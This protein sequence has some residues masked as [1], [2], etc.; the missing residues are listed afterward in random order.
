MLLALCVL[1]LCVFAPLRETISFFFL[2]R[3]LQVVKNVKSIAAA[4]M[5]EKGR[6]SIVVR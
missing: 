2:K 4:V 6:A 1:C 5:I 3:K